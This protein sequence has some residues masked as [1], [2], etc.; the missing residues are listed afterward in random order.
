MCYQEH[1]ADSWLVCTKIHVPSGHGEPNDA[2]P[3]DKLPVH[4][5]CV[6]AQKTKKEIEDVYR[7]RKLASRRVDFGRG[8]RLIV[9]A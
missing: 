5:P 3:H 8:G 4:P 7:A 2:A 6:I 1:D 9:P